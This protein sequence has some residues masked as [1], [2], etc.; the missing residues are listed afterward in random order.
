MLINKFL[1]HNKTLIG[2]LYFKHKNNNFIQQIIK[3]DLY[4]YYEMFT[5][6]QNNTGYL[7]YEVKLDK[8]NIVDTVE[9]RLEIK[10][11]SIDCDRLF[12][13][14][15]IKLKNTKDYNDYRLGWQTRMS[16]NQI[17]FYKVPL[18]IRELLGKKTDNDIIVCSI[19]K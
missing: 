11:N 17:S 12:L 15:D 9:T 7:Y 10:M 1:H 8:N 4:K 6:G 5:L 19:N 2:Q 16:F 14:E 13:C 18:S 3:K